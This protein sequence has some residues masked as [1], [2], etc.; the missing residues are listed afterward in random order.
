MTSIIVTHEMRFARRIAT[1]V[2][3]L[4]EKGVY[5]LGT[6]AE[7]FDAPKKP[8]TRRFLYNNRMYEKS[9]TLADMDQHEIYGDM[10][11][12]IRRYDYNSGQ[13]KAFP[14]IMDELIYPQLQKSD[15]GTTATVRLICSETS[16]EHIVMVSFDKANSPILADLDFLNMKL[17]EASCDSID[18]MQRENGS[19]IIIR[20]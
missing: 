5:E 8:L 1:H 16:T 19:E 20:L 14:V 9:F 17:L 12:L 18:E 15:V 11:K 7:I 13:L 6:A 3:F 10:A 4:A 2:A